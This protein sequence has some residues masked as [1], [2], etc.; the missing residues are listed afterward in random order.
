MAASV[1]RRW[2]ALS[3]VCYVCMARRWWHWDGSPHLGALPPDAPPLMRRRAPTSSTRSAPGSATGFDS[4][5]GGSAST[6]RTSS[7]RR[8]L[9]RWT[10]RRLCGGRIGRRRLGHEEHGSGAPGTGSGAL[11]MLGSW[12][13]LPLEARRRRCSPRPTVTL[14]SGL[15]SSGARG[16]GG[17]AG[18]D[19]GL[20]PARPRPLSCTQLL[21]PPAAGPVTVSRRRPTWPSHQHRSPSTPPG[22][23]GGF[24]DEELRA[25][26]RAHANH[27]GD[28]DP[29]VPLSRPS[30]SRP[31][32][33]A[34]SQGAARR[35]APE[36]GQP[37][38]VAALLEEF[39]LSVT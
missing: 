9:T 22:R 21:A 17:D 36:L 6:R 12:S 10:S 5:R 34:P 13:T 30:R 33:P 24:S 15:R 25:A 26:R 1:K 23:A 2:D 31:R 38:R 3:T 4:S 32:S 28:R 8:C 7:A 20:G 35:H 11:V 18:G 14:A 16:E 37:E 27:P 29:V 39:A 19:D